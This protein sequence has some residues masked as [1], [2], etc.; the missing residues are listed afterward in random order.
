M[1]ISYFFFFFSAVTWKKTHYCPLYCRHLFSRCSKEN[2]SLSFYCCW[3]NPALFLPIIPCP[4]TLF[5][6]NCSSKGI[7]VPNPCPQGGRVRTKVTR[8]DSEKEDELKLQIENLTQTRVSND[9]VFKL[10]ATARGQL[11]LTG[12]LTWADVLFSRVCSVRYRYSRCRYGCR[13]ELT[14]VSGAGLDVVH[15]LPNCTVPVI[16]AACLGT[17]R[18]KHTLGHLFFCFTLKLVLRER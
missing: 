14:E 7:Q 6:T 2:I 5:R 12:L 8:Q 13:T 4:E 11:I 18:T 9:I 17:C 1:Y 10:H 16:P 3:K 15:S